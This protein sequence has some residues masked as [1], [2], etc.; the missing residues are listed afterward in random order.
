M[1]IE[2]PKKRDAKVVQ[3]ARKKSDYNMVKVLIVKYLDN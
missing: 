1:L 3:V 2:T